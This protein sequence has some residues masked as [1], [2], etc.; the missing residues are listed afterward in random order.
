M[1]H[2]SLL[3]CLGLAGVPGAS[4]PAGET[5][6][7]VIDRL[8]AAAWARDKVQPARPADDPE[9]VRRIYLDLVGRIPTT[10]EALAFCRDQSWNKRS[11]LIDALLAGGE[12]PKHWREN[13][14]LFLM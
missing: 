6:A 3:L 14:H 2:R 7:Q 13:L 10:E 8:V 9:F 5:P 12:F 11:Q 1:F 4:L